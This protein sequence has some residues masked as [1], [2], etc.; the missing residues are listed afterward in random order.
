EAAA[1]TARLSERRV[2]AEADIAIGAC[3]SDAT[4]S[5]CL[6]GSGGIINIRPNS[7]ICDLGTTGSRFKDAHL[8]GSLIGS[9]TTSAVN[10]LV[11]NA[12]SAANNGIAVFSGT[13]GKIIADSGA[14]L[15]QYAALS[16][17]T[18]TGAVN[19]SATTASSSTSTGSIVTAG[20]VGIAKKTFIGDNVVIG[21]TT[22]ITSET[23]LVLRGTAATGTGG[24]HYTA[25]VS[26]DQFPTFQNLNYAH[27][28]IAMSFDGYFDNAWRSSDSGSNFTNSMISFSSTTTPGYPR[29]TR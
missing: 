14:T 21:P 11:T 2:S 3:D 20:G 6:I 17:A 1:P 19:F 5:S 7:A 25:Y 13:T 16:G 28:T 29:A 10:N 12:G 8:S 9:A 18:F 27:D 22:P 4:E 23:K 24:P 26:T 15:S